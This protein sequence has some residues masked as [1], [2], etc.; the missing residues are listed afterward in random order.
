MMENKQQQSLMVIKDG[1]ERGV[2]FMEKNHQQFL[3]LM[4]IKDG[5]KRDGRAGK[6]GGGRGGGT[7][8]WHIWGR[9]D[10]GHQHFLQTGNLE[11]K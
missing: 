2:L 9:G 7:G 6:V 8:E 3:C 5:L 11:S 4:V 10:A 1:L